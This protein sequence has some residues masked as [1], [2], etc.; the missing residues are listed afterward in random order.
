[1]GPLSTGPSCGM[2]SLPPIS[3]LRG[4]LEVSKL[5]RADAG[6]QE[7]LDAIAR[8]I[9]EALGYRTVVV[10]LYRPA[11]DD[12]HVTTVHGNDEARAVLLGQARRLDEWE[13]LFD[14]KFNRHGAYVVLNGEFDWSVEPDGRSYTPQTEPGQGADGW[15]PEDALFLPM[16]HSDGPLLGI[17][18]VDEPL[19]GRR[20]TDG[21]LE[22]L[23]ALAEHA[24]LA[25]QSAQ[26]AADAAR[27]RLALEQLL[28]VSSR[29]TA[30][31]ATDEILRAVC[32]G[33]RDAL[34]FQNVLAALS[35]PGTG[36]LD[37]RAAVGWP[38]E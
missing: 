2:N 32:S 37:P 15:H 4:L 6:L 5:M 30:E 25:V 38:L 11:W 17:L 31:P 20:P 24:S 29:L 12:F 26:E 23:V 16:R 13:P 27:H 19:S 18:S 36:R 9:A 10:N 21:E 7:I 1:M 22:V 8:V 14:E 33:V 28:G 34:G 35:E 3:P